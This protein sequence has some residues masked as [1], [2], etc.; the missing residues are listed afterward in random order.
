MVGLINESLSLVI[1]AFPVLMDV[2]SDNP[3][4][5]FG[6]VAVFLSAVIMVFRL[7]RRLRG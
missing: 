6:F 4:F 2:I 3:I 5:I 1:G 7:S